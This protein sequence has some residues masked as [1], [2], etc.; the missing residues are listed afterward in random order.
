MLAGVRLAQ[1]I[2]GSAP[3]SA[4]GN[5]A[6]LPPALLKSDKQ[7]IWFIEN[8]TMTTF[9]YAGTCRMGDDRA[10]VVDTELSV[11]GL[12]GL[13]VADASVVPFTPVSAMNAPSMM[14]GVRAAALVAAAYKAGPQPGQSQDEASP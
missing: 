10:A 13:R 1:R 8:N 9:H 14:I 5:T 4:W 12:S 3:L 2:A 11:R 6:L 7:L